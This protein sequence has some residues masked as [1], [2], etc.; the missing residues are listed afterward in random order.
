MLFMV[1]LNQFNDAC[2]TPIPYKIFYLW[3][4]ILGT[5]RQNEEDP[6]KEKP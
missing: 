6:Y 3:D 5:L 2:Y 1:F 4:T